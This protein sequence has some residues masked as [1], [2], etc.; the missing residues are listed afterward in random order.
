AVP[1]AV[2]PAVETLQDALCCHVTATSWDALFRRT[3]VHGRLSQPLRPA[4]AP[5]AVQGGTEAGRLFA[6]VLRSLVAL[7]NACEGTAAWAAGAPLAEL[8]L[9]EQIPVL[10]RLDHSVRLRQR[11]GTNDER[12]SWR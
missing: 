10:H 8:P 3:L 6:E 4:A 12:T 11:H 2:A 9:V 7:S 1:A 5:D